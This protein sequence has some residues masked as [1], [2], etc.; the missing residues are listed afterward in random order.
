MTSTVLVELSPSLDADE[1]ARRHASGEVPDRAPYGLDRL[2]EAD[3]AVLFRKL[4][5]ARPVVQASRAVGKLTGGAR[6]ESLLAKPASAD[7]R[8][9]WEERSAIPVLLTRRRGSPSGPVVTGII[10][11]TEPDANIT[12]SGRWATKTAMQRADSVFVISAGQLPVLRDQWKIPSSRVNFIHFGIDKDFW[13]P[14]SQ[15]EQP[16][17]DEAGPLVASVG[18]DRHRDHEMLLAAIR[19]V[20]AKLPESRFEL[21]TSAPRD[22]PA[23]VGTWRPSATHPELRD[24]YRR[25]RVVAISTRENLHVSGMTAILEAM[26]MGRVVVATRTPG[27]EDYVTPGVTGV[28]VPVNDRD[29]MAGALVELLADP[30]RCAEMGAAAR[31]RVAAGLSTEAMSRK[32]AGLIRSVL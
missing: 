3:L 32:L 23:E 24:L 2:A 15:P 6:W 1:W 7:A 9:F 25:A 22:I 12:G 21:V 27:I 26:A 20:H 17:G 28:L 31:E 19:E 11:N 4:P 10:W 5:H 14:E 18:N 29:A 13:S 16:E 8:F 30:G